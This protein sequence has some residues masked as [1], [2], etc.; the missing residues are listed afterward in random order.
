MQAYGV[1]RVP[2][3]PRPFAVN[4]TYEAEPHREALEPEVCA[5]VAPR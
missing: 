4:G 3:Q 5:S 2:Q 1:P